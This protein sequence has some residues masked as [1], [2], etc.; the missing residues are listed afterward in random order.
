MVGGHEAHAGG[1]AHPAV[2]GIVAVV[3][4]EEVMALGNG[5][6]AGVVEPGGP[7]I[8][9]PM[10]G[11]FGQG[12]DGLVLDADAADAHRAVLAKR[13]RTC[14]P[15]S[16]ED[17]LEGARRGLRSGFAVDVKNPAL[18]LDTVARQAHDPLDEV[19]PVDGVA[20]H[21]DIAAVGLG[22]EQPPLEGAHR[23]RA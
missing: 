1:L 18:H 4:H 10:R 21:H 6:D 14:G 12:L 3:A 23:E 2:D 13:Q 16:R 8:E 11:A 17:L 5:E 9:H 15:L 20:E 22:E 19:L 7:H